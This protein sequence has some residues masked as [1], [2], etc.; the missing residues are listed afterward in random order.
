MRDEKREF[1]KIKAK[2]RAAATCHVTTPG[3]IY[4]SRTV[5]VHQNR[6]DRKT[7]PVNTVALTES[8]NLMLVKSP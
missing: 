1:K 6:E 8:A 3:D 4:P 2:E 7:L 5:K